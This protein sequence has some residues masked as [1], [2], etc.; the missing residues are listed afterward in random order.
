[1]N[2]QTSEP[3][4]YLVRISQQSSKQLCAARRSRLPCVVHSVVPPVLLTPTRFDTLLPLRQL[5]LQPLVQHPL[6]RRLGDTKIAGAQALE[7]ATDAFVPEYLPYAVQAIPVL[8]LGRVARPLGD[9]LVQLQPRLDQPNWIRRSAGRNAR[10]DRRAQVHPCRFLPSVEIVRDQTFA[11]AIDV[12]IDGPRR[13]DTYEVGAETFEQSARAFLLLYSTEDLKS[14]GEVEEACLEGVCRG[15][16]VGGARGTELGLVEVGL[17]AGFEDVEGCGKSC[18]CHATDTKCLERIMI[19]LCLLI[20]LFVSFFLGR[21]FT[22]A[23]FL[24]GRRARGKK[25]IAWLTLLLPDDAMTSQKAVVSWFLNLL[26]ASLVSP[27]RFLWIVAA[28]RTAVVHFERVASLG[29]CWRPSWRKL[30]APQRFAPWR[31]DE[32]LDRNDGVAVDLVN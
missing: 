13:N 12:E 16:G 1:M 32:D 5:L 15:V 28:A 31:I 6:Q 19:S 27:R 18:G 9:V 11:V 21:A 22:S 17:E 7:E 20:S 29:G 30:L 10:R 2:H 3:I 24:T 23:N 25:K 26:H 4:T 8:P 14:L